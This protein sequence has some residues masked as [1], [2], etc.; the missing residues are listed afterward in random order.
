MDTLTDQSAGSWVDGGEDLSGPV[1][2]KSSTGQ[3]M[4]L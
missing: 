2:A 1:M 3:P 4:G